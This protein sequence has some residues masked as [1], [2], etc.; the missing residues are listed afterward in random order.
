MPLTVCCEVTLIGT[1]ETI[2][3]H[4]VKGLFV[5]EGRKN[6]KVPPSPPC[7]KDDRGAGGADRYESPYKSPTTA[8]SEHDAFVYVFGTY[9]AIRVCDDLCRYR[10]G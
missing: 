1:I 9:R 5:V 4:L 10:A 7:G 3:S 8:S 6:L 2:R